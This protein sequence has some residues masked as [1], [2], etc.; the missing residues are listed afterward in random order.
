MI[1]GK[2]RYIGGR[3]EGA[4]RFE[5]LITKNFNLATI[6]GE[7]P[8]IFLNR[9]ER[10][11]SREAYDRWLRAYQRNDGS[12]LQHAVWG[13]DRDL[14]EG[15]YLWG[16]MDDRYATNA[17]RVFAPGGLDATKHVEGKRACVI[18]AWDGTECLLL[19]AL[20]ASV[21]DAIEEVKD[22]AEMSKTQFDAW[23]VPG[24]VRNASLYELNIRQCWQSYDLLYVPGVLYHLTDLPAAMAIFWSMLRPGGALAFESVVD[25]D[26]STDAPAAR[27]LGASIPG[28][29]WWAPN[30]ACYNALLRDGGFPDGHAVEVSRGRGW[31]MGTRSDRLPS[32]E[33]GAAGFSRTDLLREIKVLSR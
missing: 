27:Y 17:A 16:A 3:Y 25:V 20:G 29:N 28:W 22:F 9:V 2:T 1:P 26:I 7:A 13:A 12:F 14:G 11:G 30:A 5:Q 24:E 18:G 15:H 6:S 4:E 23:C 32:L 33:C 21:I 19:R 8:E 31:W 10:W